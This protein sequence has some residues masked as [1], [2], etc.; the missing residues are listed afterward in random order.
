MDFRQRVQVHPKQKRSSPS[1]L[2]YCVQFNGCRSGTLL[3]D[4]LADFLFMQSL[5]RRYPNRFDSF[6][7]ICL[8]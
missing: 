3:E 1:L 4:L 7:D 5:A 8:E 6:S 2:A